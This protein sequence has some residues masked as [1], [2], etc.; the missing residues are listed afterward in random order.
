MAPRKYHMDRRAEAAGQT[1]K[2]IVEATYAL[3]AEKGVAATTFRDISARA[4]VGIG[5]V[6]H[7]F[8]TYDD[9]IAACG[10][11]TMALGRPPR[12]E[13]FDGVDS[14]VERVRILVREV[15]AFYGRAPIIGRVRPERY[16]FAVLEKAFHHEEES[17]R[18]L[19][20]EA[21]RGTRAGTRLRALV[22]ALLDFNTYASLAAA[23]LDHEAGVDE[24]TTT[25]LARLRAKGRKG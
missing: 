21:L 24:I 8:P 5:T 13:M 19:I 10:D 4:D 11:H 16:R 18:T 7:H 9:V 23:G 15:F 22:F 25:I 20:A 2:R 14:A 12:A 3:H 1:R 6:Y 17:R